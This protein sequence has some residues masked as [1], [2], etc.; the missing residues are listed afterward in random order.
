[1]TATIAATIRVNGETRPWQDQT[2]GDLL[3]A[4]GI[5]LNQGGLAVALNEHVVPRSAWAGT[6]LKP[7]DNVE[8]V[9]IVRGG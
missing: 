1:M 7:D 8:I 3:R 2:V 5:G 9:H 6:R 4:E